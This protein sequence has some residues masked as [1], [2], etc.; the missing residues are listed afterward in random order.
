MSG[1]PPRHHWLLAG[2]RPMSPEVRAALTQHQRACAA[3][4]EAFALFRTLGRVER[5]EAVPETVAAGCAADADLHALADPVLSLPAD[6][7]TRHVA[8]CPS[9]L[10]RLDRRLAR[11]RRDRISL[12]N[13]A[14]R[15]RSWWVRFRR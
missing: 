2:L 11:A 13:P 8:G 14:P 6:D 9:C 7:V 5:D 12:L 1:C 3:C 15:T 4:Q 10:V